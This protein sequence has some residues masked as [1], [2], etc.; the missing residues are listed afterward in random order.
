MENQENSTKKNPG[1]DLNQGQLESLTIRLSASEK[2]QLSKEAQ[3]FDMSVSELVRIRTFMK[4]SRAIEILEENN[5]LKQTLRELKVKLSFYDNNDSA[6][7]EG[8]FIKMTSEEQGLF[9]NL[10]I[11]IKDIKNYELPRIEDVICWYTM[12]GMHEYLIEMNLDEF[13][14]KE[15]GLPNQLCKA[16]FSDYYERRYKAEDEEEEE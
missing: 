7:R 9:K 4:Q 6:T 1:E 5:Q 3:Q 13:Q 16:I 10:I 14:G 12:W 2:E 11:K 8:V 15:I